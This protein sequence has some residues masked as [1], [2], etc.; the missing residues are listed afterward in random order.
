[1]RTR[2]EGVPPAQLNNTGAPAEPTFIAR[3][4]PTP[5][6]SPVIPH[7]ATLVAVAALPVIE[8]TIAF[9]TSKSVAQTLV[10]LAPVAPIEPVIVREL[11]PRARLPPQRV[12]VF[13]E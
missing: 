3:A 10:T 12:R 2:D 13:A 7:T 4:V 11:L 6:P 1:M 9:V 5:V 8:P